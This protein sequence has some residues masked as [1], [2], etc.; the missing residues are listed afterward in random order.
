M[1]DNTK[2][3][4]IDIGYASRDFNIDSTEKPIKVFLDEEDNWDPSLSEIEIP[5]LSLTQKDLVLVTSKPN[6]NGWFEAFKACDKNRIIGITH[7]HFVNF[8]NF[9]LS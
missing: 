7:L 3:K 9:K 2:T 6:E 1:K 4:V 5:F 8:L